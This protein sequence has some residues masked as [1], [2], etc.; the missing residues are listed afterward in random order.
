[1]LIDDV[2]GRRRWRRSWRFN[3]RANRAHSGKT[4]NSGAYSHCSKFL[5]DYF[6]RKFCD[7]LNPCAAH[8]D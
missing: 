5:Q 1:M 7:S 8:K 2:E 4:G 6:A 3:F